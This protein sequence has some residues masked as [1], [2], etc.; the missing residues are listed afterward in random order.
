[1]WFNGIVVEGFIINV[2]TLGIS[3]IWVSTDLV[4]LRV[5]VLVCTVLAPS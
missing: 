5:I 4:G 3:S 2:V 1:M